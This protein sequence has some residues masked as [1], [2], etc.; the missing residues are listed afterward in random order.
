MRLMAAMLEMD[1]CFCN[2]NLLTYLLEYV[3]HLECGGDRFETADSKATDNRVAVIRRSA[4]IGMS[5][6]P[7][8]CCLRT[9]ACFPLHPLAD[10]LTISETAQQK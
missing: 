10:A 5:I 1:C 6:M 9:P 3:K 8:V 7:S 4:A 2:F